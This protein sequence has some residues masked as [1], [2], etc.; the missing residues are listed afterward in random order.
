MVSGIHYFT[1][2]GVPFFDLDTSKNKMGTIPCGKNA[3]SPAPANA[4]K[5]QGGAGDGSVAWL[6]LTAKDGATGNLMEVYRLNTAGGAAPKTCA[7]MPAAFSVEYATEYWF[8]K[9]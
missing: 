1:A 6:K 8:W 5:G 7:G 9:K 2:G 4:V 3:S